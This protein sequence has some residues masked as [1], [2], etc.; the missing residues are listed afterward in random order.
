MLDRCRQELK[1]LERDTSKLEKVLPPFPRITYTEAVKI[2]RAS[3]QHTFK[4]EV[5]CESLAMVEEALACGVPVVSTDCP[6][7]PR[8]LLRGG[9]LGALVPV[10]G[11]D[12]SLSTTASRSFTNRRSRANRCSDGRR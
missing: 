7:G 2:L 6:S 4:F 10:G 5:E 12:L 11:G 1:I 9:R 3:A 8:E